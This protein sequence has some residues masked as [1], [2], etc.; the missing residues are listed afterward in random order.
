MHRIARCDVNV[1]F[2]EP[3]TDEEKRK[4]VM[5]DNW[6]NSYSLY[7][8]NLEE[9]YRESVSPQWLDQ[10]TRVMAIL[11]RESELLEIARLVG[12]DSLS[13]PDQLLLETAK[14]VREDR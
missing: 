11:Q 7:L 12:K 4:H 8:D 1:V 2:T 10:R 9:Y 6:L 5:Y 3:V 13:A 14:L